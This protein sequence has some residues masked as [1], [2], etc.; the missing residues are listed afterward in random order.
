[1]HSLLTLTF[2]FLL[3]CNYLS[4]VI[5]LVVHV[6]ARQEPTFEYMVNLILLVSEGIFIDIKKVLFVSTI[7][8]Y[9]WESFVFEYDPCDTY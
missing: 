6:E 7:E 2:N 5:A 1:M 4:R 9:N 8:Y 3:L